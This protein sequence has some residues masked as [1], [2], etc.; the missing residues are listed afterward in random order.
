MLQRLPAAHPERLR[1]LHLPVRDRLDAG[2]VVF[3][4]IRRVVQSQPQQ[5]SR[6]GRQPDDGGDRD[7]WAVDSAG[8]RRAEDGEVSALDLMAVETSLTGHL[9]GQLNVL[10]L[11]ADAPIYIDRAHRPDFA[12]RTQLAQLRSVTLK[13]GEKLHFRYRVVIHPGDLTDAHIADL[14]KSYSLEK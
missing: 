3:G 13:P 7:L 6:E 10:P 1:R 14:Y 11:R 12:S 5:R 9:H 2:P 8:Q 4:L